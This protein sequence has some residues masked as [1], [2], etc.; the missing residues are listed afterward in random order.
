[1]TSFRVQKWQY[2]R[3][4][5]FAQNFF[6]L[7]IIKNSSWSFDRWQYF[8]HQN[9]KTYV[10][11]FFPSLFC[12]KIGKFSPRRFDI[13]TAIWGKNSSFV[14]NFPPHQNTSILV[15]LAIF[16]LKNGQNTNILVIFDLKNFQNTSILVILDLKNSQNTSILV[17]FDLKNV[18]IRVFW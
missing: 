15:I 3:F 7:K 2:L 14:H 1:M 5:I 4:K 6:L 8:G 12:W 11:K 10:S 18:K 17:I 9:G 13:L 16:D